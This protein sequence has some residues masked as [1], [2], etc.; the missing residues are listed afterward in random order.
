MEDADREELNRGIA[1]L[2]A[3]RYDDAL[4]CLSNVLRHEPD[5]VLTVLSAG[6]AA[7]AL[8]RLPEATAHFRHAVELAPSAEAELGWARALAARGQ[9]E[10]AVW[11]FDQAASSS[12]EPLDP[13]I[14][15]GSLMLDLARE[16]TADT[17][18][19]AWALQEAEKRYAT[20]SRLDGAPAG[21][22]LRLGE[23]RQE[24]NAF[25]KALEA[26]EMAA[27]RDPDLPEA[28]IGIAEM[29]NNL[30][31]YKQARRA[32]EPVLARGDQV[33][34]VSALKAR[35]ALMNSLFG[36]REWEEGCEV[37]TGV[38]DL[39]AGETPETELLRETLW[40][41]V[42]VQDSVFLAQLGKLDE[43]IEPAEEAARSGGPA[44]S[45]ALYMLGGIHAARGDY[46]ALAEILIRADLLYPDGP[47]TDDVDERVSVVQLRA[48]ILYAKHRVDDA[49]KLLR[50]EC[51][52]LPERLEFHIELV[53]LIARERD[54]TTGA[55]A[56]KWQHRLL[57][58]VADARRV[59]RGRAQLPSA[60]LAYGALEILEGNAEGARDRLRKAVQKDPR[61]YQAHALL[62]AAAGRLR[63]H[64]EAAQSFATAVRLAP[65]T[66]SYKL[67]LATSYVHLGNSAAAEACYRE[68]LACAPRNVEA[69]VGLGAVLGGREEADPSIY[70]EA[71]R[72]LN[73]ALQSADTM[74]L[75]LSRQCASIRLSK[76]RRAAIYHQIGYVRTRE[77]EA[78]AAAG[79]PRRR[80]KLLREAR[81]AFTNALREDR[82]MFLAKR[83]KERVGRE[84][85]ALLAE[86]PKWLLIAVI[87]GLLAV[88]SSSFFLKFPELEELSGPTY[89]AMTL[90]LLVLLM[91]ASYMDRLRSLRVAGVSMEKDVEV[92][93]LARKLG[94]EADP[95]IIELLQ[96]D[97]EPP[98]L[99]PPGDSEI[100]SGPDGNGGGGGGASGQALEGVAPETGDQAAKIAKSGAS[101]D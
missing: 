81:D 49:Y 24:R 92:T 38:F 88:L 15:A 10:Q 18:R 11:H 69:L 12:E 83:A 59:L 34:V 56:A 54:G 37:V 65:H 6:Q 48:T 42:K 13:L 97:I 33:A 101:V 60:D 47:L 55:E 63:K 76:A 25:R 40:A 96:I 61:S 91:A 70:E 89:S 52:D 90:G 87:C 99:P 66:F 39:L 79:N 80:H 100:S 29:A 44:V 22:A 86:R 19:R 62:G 14:A 71:G 85:R 36:L 64:E 31:R 51:R 30:E 27:K 16:S 23:A 53:R 75:D 82:D 28:R 73:E 95:H 78:E 45:H 58:A 3:G 67:A 4:T 50:D 5:D 57:R 43:A 2:A 17:A 32:V 72:H 68:V 98:P 94:V 41:L 8:D 9:V 35:L 26:F 93:T 1:F 77:F 21:A 7:L 20:A 74:N 84:H 46:G